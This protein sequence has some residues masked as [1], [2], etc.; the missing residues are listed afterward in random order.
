VL[1][2][3]KISYLCVIYKK[4]VSIYRA[5]HQSYL[6][7]AKFKKFKIFCSSSKSC[8][9]SHGKFV[10]YLNL[11]WAPEFVWGSVISISLVIKSGSFSF[12]RDHMLL[13]FLDTHITHTQSGV[14]TLGH[15][16]TVIKSDKI[17]AFSTQ[18]KSFK[19]GQNRSSC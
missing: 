12:T 19:T 4:V 14:I 16:W 10:T 11:L 17:P 8:S 3:F 7:Q 15:F 1:G 6:N 18:S 2:S 5:R 9:D 13:D